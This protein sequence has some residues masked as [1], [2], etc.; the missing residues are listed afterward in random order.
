MNIVVHP[1]YEIQLNHKQG[2]N[3]DK[4]NNNDEN[5]TIMLKERS[6][7]WKRI[8]FISSYIWRSM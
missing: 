4:Q 7:T 6:Q 5:Y 1:H 8:Y 3:T 2:E